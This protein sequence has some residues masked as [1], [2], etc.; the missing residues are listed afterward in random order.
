MLP[1][2]TLMKRKSRRVAQVV[3]VHG[4]ETMA[5]ATQGYTL[6]A[7]AHQHAQPLILLQEPAI[8]GV[9]EKSHKSVGVLFTDIINLTQQLTVNGGEWLRNIVLAP[10]DIALKAVGK[11]GAGE[12][13]DTGDG[14]TFKARMEGRM[15][16][17][18][19]QEIPP[20]PI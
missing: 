7:L 8:T 19:A 16:L 15:T 17:K 4:T 5:G 13:K 18:S 20:E 14:T 2:P 3:V 11:H 1:R 9:R 10:N 12:I 6:L